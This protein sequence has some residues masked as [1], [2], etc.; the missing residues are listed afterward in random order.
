VDNF[1]KN[2]DKY[3]ISENFPLTISKI[4]DVDI[5]NKGL[6]ALIELGRVSE[7]FYGTKYAVTPLNEIKFSDRKTYAGVL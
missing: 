1:K 7:F 6:L 5:D 3:K 2:K 4:V